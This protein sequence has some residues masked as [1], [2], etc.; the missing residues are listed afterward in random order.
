MCVTEPIVLFHRQIKLGIQMFSGN[1]LI[2]RARCDG[3]STS[4]GFSI[5]PMTV[6]GVWVDTR[7]VK[8]TGV[9]D[10]WDRAPFVH[11]DSILLLQPLSTNS[12][13]LGQPQR[14][15]Y[16]SFYCFSIIDNLKISLGCIRGKIG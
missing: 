4:F 5:P 1:V 15:C 10:R 16:G 14:P 7:D 2:S 6:V 13:R 3:I 11:R 8:R 9:G 12:V